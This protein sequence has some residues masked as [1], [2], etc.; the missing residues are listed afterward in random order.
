MNLLRFLEGFIEKEDV[1]NWEINYSQFK[2]AEEGLR[3]AICTL[4]NGYMG[5]RGTACESPASRIHYPGTYISGL[6]NKLATNIAG[7]M[8]YNESM[9]NCPNWLFL[10]FRVERGE[11]FIPSAAKPTSYK[12]KLDMKNGILKREIITQD[13]RG[14]KSKIETERIV[15]MSS[16]HLAAI[17]YVITPQNYDGWLVIRSGLDAGVRNKN[18]ARYRQLKSRHLIPL[19]SGRFAKNGIFISSRTNQSG[20]EIGQAAK[21]RIF[22]NE[23]EFNPEISIIKTKNKAIYQELRIFVRKKQRYVIEKTVSVYTSKDKNIKRP[24]I[25]SINS[26]KKAVRFNKLIRTHKQVWDNLWKKCDIKIENDLFSQRV[27]RLHIF[28][29]LQTASVHNINIDAGLPARGLHGEAYRGHIFWDSLFVMHFFNLHLPNVAKALILYRYRRLPQALRN[30]KTNGFKGAMFPWQSGSSGQEETPI[31]HLNPLSGKWGPDYSHFQRHVSFAIAYNIWEYWQRTNDLTFLRRYGAEM[32]LSLAQFGASLARYSHKDDRYHI[33]GVMGPDEFHEKLP[34]RGKA[35]FKDNAYTNFLVVWVLSAAAEILKV[36]AP[37]D[38]NKLL[39]KL[40]IDNNVLERWR[41][42][43]EKMALILNSQGII[44]QFEGYFKLKE[45]NWP[46][47]RARYAKIQRID[48]ILKAEGKSPDEYKVSK[49][50]DVLMIFYLFAIEEVEN[51]FKA[52]GYPFNKNTLRKNYD[53]Y[54]KRTSHGSTL[55]KVVHCYMALMLN[56]TKESWHWFLEVLRSDIHDT[57]GGTTPEGIHLGV[58][59][60]SLDIVFRG[61]AGINILSDRIKVSPRLPKRWK[62]LKLRFLYKR[63]WLNLVIRNE[64]LSITILGP[65]HKR[66]DVPIEINGKLN[67]LLFGKV[68]QYRLTKKP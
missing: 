33:E 63:H 28:H 18:V 35:G 66:F 1:S 24:L 40:E 56:R 44:S 55:S 43:R 32:L 3:E 16:P 46:L 49:Q 8:V 53:Y 19:S 17:Q 15:H 51:I 59:G 38:R 27:L 31:S 11:W 2:P 47:Y 58:M 42:I 62:G 39:K 10:T 21:V 36:L 9:V 48:R 34:R 64:R 67:Y 5:T 65:Q 50:A 22:N 52:I 13:R 37:N 26:V 25:S 54:V 6:Y 30:A 29:L 4:G 60:G 14:R 61:F 12:Q 7:K 57:Q 20:I 45:L 68:Y 23:G 41:D